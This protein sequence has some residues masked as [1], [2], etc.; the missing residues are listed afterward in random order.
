MKKK[1]MLVLTIVV[2]ILAALTCFAENDLKG[3]WKLIEAQG[4]G[5]EGLDTAMIEM[6]EA[7]GGSVKM[8]FTDKEMTLRAEM[9]GEANSQT[10]SYKAKG[11][12][13]EIGNRNVISYE[14]KDNMLTL[15]D[16][17]SSMVFK[18]L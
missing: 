10:E 13:I 6:V 7:F 1:M 12:K 16:G 15:S 9:F 14:V 8:T 18:K 4:S 17:S 3:T 5:V 11:N 2:L